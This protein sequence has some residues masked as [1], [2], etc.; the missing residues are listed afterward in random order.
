[1]A[2]LCFD[3]APGAKPRCTTGCGHLGDARGP[4]ILV[5]PGFQAPWRL[6]P[7]EEARVQATG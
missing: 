3:H 5:A 2:S 6:L 7:C 1:M 4:S